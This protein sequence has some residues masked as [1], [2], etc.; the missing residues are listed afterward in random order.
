MHHSMGEDDRTRQI[1]V[2]GDWLRGLAMAALTGPPRLY[3]RACHLRTL[4]RD[5]FGCWG[6]QTQ[7]PMRPH[8]VIVSPPAFHEHLHLSECSKQFS[9]QQAIA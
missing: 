2:N 1:G 4:R 8:L 7:S 3:Q 9:I 6:L 5:C